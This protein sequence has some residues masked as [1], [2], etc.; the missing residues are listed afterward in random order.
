MA[1]LFIV[2]A[3]FLKLWIQKNIKVT[4]ILVGALAF[5]L[6]W[7]LKYYFA[8]ILLIALGGL[9][10]VRIILWIKPIQSPLKITLLFLLVLIVPLFLVTQLHPNFYLSRILEV[11]VKN[12]EAFRTISRPENLIT[13]YHLRATPASIIINMPWA[14]ISGIFQPFIWNTKS[15]FQLLAGIESFIVFILFIGV[16]R[17]RSQLLKSPNFLLVLG[18]LTFIG[19]LAIFLAL[20][21]PN[22]GTLV[23]YRVGFY[24][25][26]IF[27]L[28]LAN[29]WLL[30][31]KRFT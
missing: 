27:L 17:Q 20:S 25:F 1:G 12:Y 4:E 30:Q 8:G 6:L 31:R 2:A 22:V 16:F 3:V 11:V 23:R 15:F 28:L 21:T 26:L 9:L 5:W 14:L 24:P 18:V 7:N 10:L 13:Y 19:L 29:P